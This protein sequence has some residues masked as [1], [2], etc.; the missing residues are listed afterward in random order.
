LTAP[1]RAPPLADEA[2][3]RGWPV[4][5]E[6]ADHLATLTHG[7]LIADRLVELLS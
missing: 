4:L 3:Q 6:S 1:S 5:R 7:A 2:E